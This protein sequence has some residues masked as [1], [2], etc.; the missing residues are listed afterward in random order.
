MRTRWSRFGDFRKDLGEDCDMGQ[1]WGE[2]F[3]KA[4][5]DRTVYLP[6]DS[7]YTELST[8]TRIQTDLNMKVAIVILA[9]P[10][11]ESP[12]ALTRTLNAL[13]VADESRREG[14]ELALLFAGGGTRWPSELSQLS[15]PG[16]VLYDGVREFVV[17]ASRSC[18]IRNEAIDGLEKSGVPLVDDNRVEGTQGIASTRRYLAEGWSVL[19]F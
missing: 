2:P 6:L 7:K 4:R 5:I 16:H 18:A 9:D 17:G 13:A 12:E 11:T 19:T 1:N 8:F 10:R 3:K 15:H 14:D